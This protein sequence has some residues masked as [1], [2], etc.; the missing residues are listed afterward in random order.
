MVL[1]GGLQD[2]GK[3]HGLEDFEKIKQEGVVDQVQLWLLLHIYCWIAAADVYAEVRGWD[4]P[5]DAINKLS[6]FAA[7]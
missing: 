1:F 7:V 3:K 2:I 6:L 5:W 4:S